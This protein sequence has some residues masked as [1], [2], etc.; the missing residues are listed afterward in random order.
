MARIH[1]AAQNDD[2]ASVFYILSLVAEGMEPDEITRF[3]AERLLK[4]RDEITRLV[5]FHVAFGKPLTK[6]IREAAATLVR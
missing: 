6:R 4:G 2:L 3:S 1:P 5:L